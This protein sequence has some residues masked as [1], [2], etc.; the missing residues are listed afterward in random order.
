MISGALGLL[1]EVSRQHT[2]SLIVRDK[3]T[4]FSTV[5]AIATVTHHLSCVDAGAR[6]RLHLLKLNKSLVLSKSGGSSRDFT[7]LSILGQRGPLD[8][9]HHT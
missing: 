2:S 4:H 5:G 9:G 7:Q 3:R 8:I 6:T 1:G